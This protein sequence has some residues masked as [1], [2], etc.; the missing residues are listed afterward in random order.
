M[1]VFAF[2]AEPASYTVD[3]NLKV[4]VP[5]GIDYC[6]LLGNSEAKNTREEKVK[7]VLVHFSKRHQYYPIFFHAKIAEQIFVCMVTTGKT[8]NM[9][10]TKH[11]VQ[12]NAF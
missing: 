10:I 5:M 4:Y 7:D 2:L 11:K 1:N 6:Y 9:F 12:I 8:I 3:R